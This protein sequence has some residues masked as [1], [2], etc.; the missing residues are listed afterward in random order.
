[1]PAILRMPVVARAL[2]IRA[3][4]LPTMALALVLG[5]FVSTAPQA[6]ALTVTRKVSN[7]LS[8]AKHQL[9]DPYAYGAAGP[10]RFDCS[11][12]LYYSYRRAGFTKFP[13]TSDSQ[14][15]FVRRVKRANLRPG[16]FVFFHNGGDVYHAAIFAGRKD[17]HVVILHSPNSGG[18][19]SYTRP[20]S[21]SWF[22]GT[23]RPR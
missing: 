4:L 5:L 14:A 2:L 19:V 9:G 22:G 6:E 7:G 17:G 1:M 18:R 12:L 3:V 20:W 16:D 11:G 10:D 8:I 15:R 21:N 13:R 23:L